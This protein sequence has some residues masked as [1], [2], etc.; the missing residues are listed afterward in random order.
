MLKLPSLNDIRDEGNFTWIAGST[1]KFTNWGY[2]EPNNKGGNED[3][4][5]LEGLIPNQYEQVPRSQAWNDG[6]YGPNVLFFI[7]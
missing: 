1:S 6:V 4:T 2:G 7:C 3:C 5:I